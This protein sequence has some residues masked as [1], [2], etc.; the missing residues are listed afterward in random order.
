MAI[1]TKVNT[2]SGLQNILSVTDNSQLQNYTNDPEELRPI[3]VG[4]NFSS[5]DVYLLLQ[6]IIENDQNLFANNANLSL[7]FS[8]GILPKNDPNQHLNATNTLTTF[9]V[10]TG[11]LIINENF[12]SVSTPYTFTIGLSGWTAVTAS[13][14]R[15]D[16]IEVD[17]AGN[18]SLSLGI[19]ALTKPFLQTILDRTSA[20]K[21]PLYSVLLYN[22]GAGTEI[23]HYQKIAPYAGFDEARR[24]IKALLSR[25]DTYPNVFEFI[26]NQTRHSQDADQV[27]LDRSA[28]QLTSAA[29]FLESDAAFPPEPTDPFVAIAPNNRGL[30]HIPGG[31]WDANSTS[32]P[33][34]PNF[35]YPGEN[36]KTNGFLY[37]PV[38]QGATP[39]DTTATIKNFKLGIRYDIVGDVA[40]VANEGL[41]VQFTRYPLFQFAGDDAVDYNLNVT[42]ATAT[43]ITVNNTNILNVNTLALDNGGINQSIAAGDFVLVTSGTG[44]GQTGKITSVG[45]QTI[46]LGVTFTTVLDNT[47]KIVIFKNSPTAVSNLAWSAAQIN[48]DIATNNTYGSIT[49]GGYAADPVADGDGDRFIKIVKSGVSVNILKKKYYF[50]LTRI[51]QEGSVLSDAPKIHIDNHFT[52]YSNAN[53][54]SIYYV[55]EYAPPTGTYPVTDINGDVFKLFDQYGDLASTFSQRLLIYGNPYSEWDL[56]AADLNDYELANI[57]Y[58]VDISPGQ[59][60]VDVTLGRIAFNSTVRPESV[61]GTYYLERYNANKLTTKEIEKL[62]SIKQSV[63]DWMADKFPDN[64]NSGLAY[65]KKSIAS[66]GDITIPGGYIAMMRDDA[67]LVGN[68]T[69]EDDAELFMIQK[70]QPNYIDFVTGS[71]PFWDEN[72]VAGTGTVQYP[73]YK[74]YT[75]ADRI[76][77][78]EFT[79]NGDN[80]INSINYQLSEDA[81]LNYTNLYTKNFGYTTGYLTSVT[82]T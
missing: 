8:E 20:N 80:T 35:V 51:V 32:Q 64:K 10:G 23:I 39:T 25:N 36:L 37:L 26:P 56:V 16:L 42:S 77:K 82:W 27:Y 9:T 68:I 7:L 14:Y 69:I 18:F 65:I 55:A 13:N 67:T 62:G 79:Y 61:Y 53:S 54:C 21:F 71:K 2:G 29:T 57:D 3:R 33:A 75:S 58:G 48:A 12:V 11:R 47:S 17:I 28:G 76:I 43:S 78:L 60:W 22:S 44:Y 41:E 31:T 30:R 6:Q 4:G 63:E 52:S 19:E 73:Q 34:F 49:Q 72:Y 5:N 66:Q 50:I 45:T 40:G 70:E 38:I 1:R 46:Q 24:D 81:G 59:C 15:A 74:Y